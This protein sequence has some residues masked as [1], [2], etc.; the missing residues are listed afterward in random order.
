MNQMYCTNCGTVAYAKTFTKGHFAFEVILWLCFLIPGLIYSVWRLTTRYQG[1]P[2]CEAPNMI[3]AGSPK[4]QELLAR[5]PAP[6]MSEPP[7]VAFR[8]PA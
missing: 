8:P 3:P 2:A 4:A 6:M 7:P 1:C 5:R